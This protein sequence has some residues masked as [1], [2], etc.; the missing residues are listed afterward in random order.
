MSHDHG[1]HDH[2]AAWE[3]Q[4]APGFGEMDHDHRQ[5]ARAVAALEGAVRRGGDP[6]VIALRWFGTRHELRAAHGRPFS[7]HELRLARSIGQVLEARYSAIFDP[8]LMVEH[9]ELFQGTID[10]HYVGAFL[11]EIGCAGSPTGP[12]E[13]LAG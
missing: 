13:D 10:D 8:R 11:D 12:L 3:A 9:A 7:E 1:D 2:D 6:E 4:L 5:Q